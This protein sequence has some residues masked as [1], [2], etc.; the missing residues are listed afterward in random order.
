RVEGKAGRQHH[1][2]LGAGYRNVDPPVVVAVVGRAEGGDGVDLQQRRMAGRVDRLPQGGDVRGDAGGGLVVH[3]A[4]RLDA[5]VAIFGQTRFQLRRID[6]VA[7]ITLHIVD[8]KSQ[9]LR[10]T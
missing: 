10:Q 4:D 7:P 1:A 6:P 2:L 5:V 9:A 8:L 3:R